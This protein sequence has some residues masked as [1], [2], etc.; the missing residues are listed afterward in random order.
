M[1]SQNQKMFN[2][3]DEMKQWVEKNINNIRDDC[4]SLLL[5]G[6]CHESMT[7]CARSLGHN[8]YWKGDRDLSQLIDDMSTV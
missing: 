4:K 3:T 2:K 6:E 7:K 5:I 8:A 1:E